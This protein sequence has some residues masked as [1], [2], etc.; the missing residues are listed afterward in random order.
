MIRGK[1]ITQDLFDILSFIYVASIE[2]AIL[3]ELLTNG[4]PFI[5]GTPF[6]KWCTVDQPYVPLVTI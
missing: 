3:K 4:V 2:Y 5:N 6:V 1:L